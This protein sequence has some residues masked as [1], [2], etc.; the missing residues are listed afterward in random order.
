LADYRL[1]TA[2]PLIL[3]L[4]AIGALHSFGVVAVAGAL[5]YLFPPGIRQEF[6]RRF[7]VWVA[8][9]AIAGV[10][11][12]PWM[13]SAF[14]RHPGH[15]EPLTAATVVYTISGWLLGYRA[16]VLP[17]WLQIGVTLLLALSVVIAIRLEPT[18][19]RTIL[20]YLLWPLAVAAVIC[21]LGKPVWLFRS[22]SFCAPLLSI[23]LGTLFSRLISAGSA[24]RLMQRTAIAIAVAAIGGAAALASVTATTPWKTQYREAAAY[25]RENVQMGD[26]VYIP[27]QVTYWG[28]AR[29]LVGP[30]W[31]SLLE[32]QDPVD[33]DKSRLWP[34]IYRRLGPRILERLHLIPR[35]RRTDGFRAPLY[36]GWSPLPEAKNARVIW[37]VGSVH[38]PFEEFHLSEVQLCRYEKVRTADFTELRVFRVTCTSS[39]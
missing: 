37:L 15:L 30:R 33:P 20:C 5:L 27:N 34:G 7:P 25:L 9:S 1:R 22:F 39:T 26:I 38:P 6:R 2:I 13:I 18:L 31:G 12:L 23:C 14:V 8:V 11:L 16:L 35:T 3:V 24:P 36:I 19:R 32:V 17:E 4:V 10:T 21:L 28:I 29:Y